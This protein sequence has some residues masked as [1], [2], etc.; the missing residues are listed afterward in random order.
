MSPA[1]EEKELESLIKQDMD[2]VLYAWS[3]INRYTE[4][5]FA[6]RG[7]G[8]Y[9]W[10]AFGKRYIDSGAQQWYMAV[11][12]S[13]PKV[14]N[15]IIDQLKKLQSHYHEWGGT[16]SR[17]KLA[18]LLADIT[19]PRLNRSF[20]TIGGSEATDI[21]MK[22]AKQFKKRDKIV[23]FWD[24]YHG[25]TGEAVGAAG[26]PSLRNAWGP[27]MGHVKVPYPY[28]YRCPFR[29]EYPE[30]GLRC[31]DFF[32]TAIL[33]EGVETIAAVIG[34]PIIGSGGVIIP[35]PEWWPKIRK[36]CDKYDILLI[37]D[38]VIT[39][40]GRTGK[41]FG[42]E[43]WNLTP[44]MMTFAKGLTSGY[45]PLGATIIHDK[46]AEFFKEKDIMAGLTY[47]G[48]TLGCA[49]AVANI[50]V[51]IEE[52]L[53]D[54]ATKMGEYMKKGLNELLEKHPSV[55]DVRSIGLMACLEL[56]KNR[57]TKEPLVPGGGVPVPEADFLEYMKKLEE[58]KEKSVTDKI[59]DFAAQ[60]GMVIIVY[61]NKICLSPPL[62]I[63]RDELDEIINILD[64]TLEI[65]DKE[66]A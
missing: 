37:A 42:V 19:P 49:A 53:V 43:N 25:S 22:I 46:I 32:E 35:P 4:R 54:N 39:G 62:I 31:A 65:P 28:C 17:A 47:F 23:S 55:G 3:S 26:R 48:H 24:S 60:N 57:E 66:T 58:A 21:A 15:A 61:D 36:M 59:Q 29:L 30:C 5:I 44:D 11:G 64:K 63:S 33:Y 52:K 14:I 38:E 40:F 18:K 7:K 56:V 12:H 50:N 9:L 13:H 27:V 2:H 1:K 51:I 20:I 41:M 8:C 10:D 16:A 45:L 6:E 34:E